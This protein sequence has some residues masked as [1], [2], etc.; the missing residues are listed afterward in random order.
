MS[1]KLHS[2]HK[3]SL[4]LLG[5]VG[6]DA[7]TLVIVLGILEPLD[8]VGLFAR[9]TELCRHRKSPSAVLARRHDA[10]EQRLATAAHH[11]SR[12]NTCA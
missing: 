7:E 8:G 10:L 11:K 5:C 1:S 2:R 12:P 4:E 3:H 9:V 6:H